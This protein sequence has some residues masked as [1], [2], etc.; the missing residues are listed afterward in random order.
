L[1]LIA[2]LVLRAARLGAPPPLSTTERLANI[3]TT[4]LPLH[5]PVAIHWNDHQVPSIEAGDD[6]DLAVALGAVHAHLRLGQM[7]VM[8]RLAT[9]RVAEIIGKPGVEM[10]R[11]LRLM[12]FDL[13]VP[14]II[15]M[16]P[17]GTRQWLKGF[18]AGV[19]HHITHAPAHPHEFALLGF[20]PEP[21]TMEQLLTASRLAATDVSWLVFGRLLQSQAK[22]PKAEWDRLWPLM[23]AGDTLPWPGTR[24]E[25]ALGLV[26]GSN[27]AAVP[28]ARSA[29]GAGMIASDPHLSVTLPPLWLIAGLHRPGLDVVGLMIPG[30][31]VVGLGRNPWL[32]WGGTSLHAASSEL[33]DISAEPMTV[34]REVI[35]VRGSAPVTLHLRET[36]FGPVVSDGI[37]LQSRKP[38]ALRWVGHRPSDEITALLGVMQARDFDQFRDALRPFAV[39]GQ[40]MVAVEAGP[41]GRAGRVIAAHLP[42][43]ADTPLPAPTAM[44]ATMWALDDLLHG[45]DFASVGEDVV[46][47][48]NDRPEPTPVPVGFFFAPPARVQRLRAMLVGLVEPQRMHA[49]QLDVLQPRSLALRDALLARLPEPATADA[50]AWRALTEWDGQYD[51]GSAGALVFEVLTSALARRLVRKPSLALL[52]AIWSGRAV[53]A[54]RIEQASVPDLHAALAKASAVLRRDHNWGGIHRLSLRHPLAALPLVG[55]RYAMQDYAAPGSNDTL[56]KTGHGLVDGRHHVTFGACARHV[57]NLADPNANQFVLLGGQ[58]GWLGSANARDQVALWQAGQAITVPLRLEAAR[59]WPHHTMLQP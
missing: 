31:P 49:L 42:R 44:P 2:R 51:T 22:L 17:D 13:A 57:S 33:V 50:P 14:G 4:G 11:A 28:A 8:R 46:A 58:D 29:S 19:N 1:A 30:L 7:E 16:L 41:M 48:A 40:T 3:P 56:N 52:T 26:R 32:A 34:R 36:A 53:I 9:G 24:E 20:V 55:R 47:S 39:P 18:L 25:A 37:L 27:S 23:Q 38:L 43:R 15:A 6:W 10:D 45:A 54:Q 21:W 5:G 35:Q 59:A 12:R